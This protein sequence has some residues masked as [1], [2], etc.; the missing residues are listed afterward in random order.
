MVGDAKNAFSLNETVLDF[1]SK[2]Y[3]DK[4]YFYGGMIFMYIDNPEEFLAKEVAE[5][6][7]NQKEPLSRLWAAHCASQKILDMLYAEYA[8]EQS[9]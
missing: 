2:I 3:I 8:G 4:F 6:T 9:E 7:Q 5:C 1:A